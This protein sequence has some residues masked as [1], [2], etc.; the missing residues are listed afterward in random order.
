[1]AN[2]LFKQVTG[3]PTTTSGSFTDIE[4]LSFT[5][6][7]AQQDYNSALVTLNVPQPYVD[8]GSSNGISYQIDVNGAS[9]IVGTWTNE[10][11]QNGRSPFTLVTMVP[12]NGGSQFVE[13]QWLSVRGGTA[14]LG[15]SASLSA[16][17]VQI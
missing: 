9:Q 17:L 15:G 16:T 7:A 13:A 11:S 12:L 14:H 8:G 3:D 5:L 6:P 1:M 4:G 2:A 10:S